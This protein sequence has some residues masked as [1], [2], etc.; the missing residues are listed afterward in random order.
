M[1][2]LL[3]QLT[4]M[5]LENIGYELITDVR[6]F[7]QN[8]ERKVHETTG[9]ELAKAFAQENPTFQINDLVKHFAQADRNGPAAYT[10][11]RH[12]VE[13]RFLTKLSPGNYQRSDVKAIAAPEPEKKPGRGAV[14]RHEITNDTLVLK[15]IRGRKKITARELSAML[16]SHG[17]SKKSASPITSR[18][19]KQKLLKLIEPG[20]FEVVQKKTPIAKK[21]P[22]KKPTRARPKR[23]RPPIAKIAEQQQSP[24]ENANG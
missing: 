24:A 4:R 20:V 16:F 13:E 1:G 14:P 8:G 15:A 5:G 11:V 21:L 9:N 22:A 19:V 23:E 18:L 12:L 17:R 2:P 7:H 6:R 10:A 3:A